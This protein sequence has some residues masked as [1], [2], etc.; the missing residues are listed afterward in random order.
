MKDLLQKHYL[1]K[2]EEVLEGFS[3]VSKLYPYIPP[4]IIWRAWEYAAY[5]RYRLTEPVLDVGCG[6]GRFF[7]LVWPQIR[8]VVGVDIDPNIVKIAKKTGAYRQV[9]VAP[10]H[11]MPFKSGTFASAFAN[12]SLEHM[13]NLPKILKNI[14]NCLCTGGEFLLSVANE[15]LLQ[16]DILTELIKL[17]GEPS[18]AALLQSE[19][20][21]YHHHVNLL[22]LEAWFDQLLA[23]GFT[24][25]EYI[26]IVP[27]LTGRLFLFLDHIWHI[28]HGTGEIGDLLPGIF[29][30]FPNFDSSLKEILR[31]LLYME[32]D[33]SVCCGAVF[34][35]QK[36][37]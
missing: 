21:A 15:K 1:L 29:L 23:A 19:Y 12:C 11:E 26:P 3:V 31:S 18:R 4:M 28:K 20:V 27:E 36:L 5:K 22:S 2:A 34:Y 7:Q 33:C 10:A 17:V 14:A 37:K 24:I 9:Y 8:D 30:T 32:R 16:W 35:V 25:K 13:D 6:D